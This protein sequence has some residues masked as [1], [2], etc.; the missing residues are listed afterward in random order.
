MLFARSDCRIKTGE[1]LVKGVKT[2]MTR[3]LELLLIALLLGTGSLA[4][5]GCDD[6]PA[7]DAGEE[8]DD[9]VDDVG[10]RFE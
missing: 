3:G 2:R 9:A 4:L 5:S 6:G 10:D 1:L 7:E 8:I